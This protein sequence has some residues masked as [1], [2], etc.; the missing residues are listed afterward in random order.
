MM[1]APLPGSDIYV[2]FNP[3]DLSSNLESEDVNL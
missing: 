2:E 3:E 1:H